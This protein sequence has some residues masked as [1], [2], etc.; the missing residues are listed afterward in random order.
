MSK[1]LLTWKQS[2]FIKDAPLYYVEDEKN[3]VL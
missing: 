3:V 2:T 1:P